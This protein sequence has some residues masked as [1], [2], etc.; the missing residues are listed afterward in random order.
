M[1]VSSIFPLSMTTGKSRWLEK[2]VERSK[3]ND[4]F[5]IVGVAGLIKPSVPVDRAGQETYAQRT[6]GNQ[7]DAKFLADG[8]QLLLRPSP[9]ERILI[10]TAGDGLNGMLP[11][12]CAP[13]GL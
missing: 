6:P 10:C 1:A 7:T 3:R 8:Q 2:I 13:A 12:Q 11:P 9:E 5:K 4:L